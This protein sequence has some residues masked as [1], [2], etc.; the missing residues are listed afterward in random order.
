MVRGGI[1]VYAW[2]TNEILIYFYFAL[3]VKRIPAVF[4]VVLQTPQI[5]VVN[6]NF[7]SS[8]SASFR[9]IGS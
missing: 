2:Q 3:L 1:R 8:I 7:D 6:F 4:Y 9:T 5:E